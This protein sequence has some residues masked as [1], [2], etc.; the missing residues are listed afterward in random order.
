M[1]IQIDR[2][3]EIKVI[4]KREDMNEPVMPNHPMVSVDTIVQ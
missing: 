4:R 3:H 2:S 1:T